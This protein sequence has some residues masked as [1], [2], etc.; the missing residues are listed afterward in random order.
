MSSSQPILESSFNDLYNSTVVAFPN[1]SL[2]QNATHPIVITKL[3]WTPFLGMQTLMVKG[4]AQNKHNGHEHNCFVVFKNVNYHA[5][6]SR[7][8]IEIIDQMNKHYLLERLSNESTQVLVRCSCGDFSWRGIHWNH[9]KK[10]LFGRD[11]KKYEALYS[12]GSANPTESEILCKHLIKIFK[13]L[14]EANLI[15]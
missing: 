3:E 2:R 11:R 4:L 7:G 10:S 8:L 13:V 5:K 6:H 15:S 9:E 12:P 14:N 1:C